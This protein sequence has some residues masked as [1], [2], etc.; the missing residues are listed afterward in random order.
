[1][2][3]HQHTNRQ[4][5]K[6]KFLVIGIDEVLDAIN[7]GIELERIFIRRGLN[8]PDI[9]KITEQNRIPCN[10]VPEAKLDSFNVQ[11]H[12][13]I[14][15]LKSKV[16]YSDIQDVI[17]LLTTE[18]KVPQFLILDGITDIRNIGAIG[19]TAYA[20][21]ID[22]MII[23]SHGVGVLNESAIA[24]SAGALEKLTICRVSD[25]NSAI[26]TLHL[27]GIQ[28]Y[29]SEMTAKESIFNLDMKIPLAILMGSED[30]GIHPELYK[31][32]DKVFRI[33][34]KN[35]FESLN[36]SVA[37][38]MILLEIMKQRMDS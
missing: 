14:I 28:V 3:Y 19:R 38:G 29:A 34:M 11:G 26:E 32:C 36:V 33:P 35:D 21:G 5:P 18:G 12:G 20:M 24:T 4:R 13:G 8:N 22:A 15:A 10:F 25:L 1:M 7:S 16:N 27:N 23:P 31:L 17:T 9:R 37:T 30:E 2:R 6:K